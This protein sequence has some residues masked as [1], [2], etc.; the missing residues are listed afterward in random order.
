[1]TYVF[2]CLSCGATAD[3]DDRPADCPDCG[4]RLEVARADL[5]DALPDSERTDL[6]RYADWLPTEGIDLADGGAPA[7]A[8]G[9]G[10][11]PLVEAPTLSATAAADFDAEG[12]DVLVKNETTNPTWS[13]KDRLASVVVPHAVADGGGDGDS[14]GG[15]DRIATASTG[16]HAAAVAAYASRAGVER[17]LAFL[18]PSSEPPHHRQSRAYGAEAVR[19]TDYGERKRLLRDLADRGW[20]VAYNLSGHY[21]GQPYVYEGYKTIAYEIVEQSESVP[22]AV[23]V[24]VGAGDGF[25][26][27]WKGFRELAARGVISGTPRMVSAESAERHP[28]AAAFETDAESVGRDEGPEPLSTSTMG[29]TSGDHALGAVRASGGAAYAADRESVEATI[30]AAGEDGVFLEPASA[31]APAVVSQAFADGVVGEGD[32]VV[33]VGTGA[34][35]AWPDK[36]VGAVG[37]SP[38]V[39]PSL[40]AVADAVPFAL[41]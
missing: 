22:D 38:T 24:P 3:P 9:E 8:M 6:W 33:A 26:G 41:D 31:L 28:L 19:L 36:T 39:D 13:W 32:T 17:V 21:T 10:W 40:D 15:A 25:Y 11:T 2:E 16:N 14:S 7:S 4:G 37:E 20:F 27:V 5:P 12:P 29:A 35:V 30:R 23:V 18:S 34:G 1:M